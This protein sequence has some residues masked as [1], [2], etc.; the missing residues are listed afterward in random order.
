M[1]SILETLYNFWEEDM[2]KHLLSKDR[3]K[4]QFCPS[5]CSVYFWRRISFGS[6]SKV[7][8]TGVYIFLKPY[9][10]TILFLHWYQVRET[11]SLAFPI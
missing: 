6:M 1:M 5:L 10:K 4:K 9:L 2:N 7:L 8:F 11:V 3:P